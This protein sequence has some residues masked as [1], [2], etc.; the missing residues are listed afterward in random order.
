[1]PIYDGSDC[2]DSLNPVFE[3]AK[4]RIGERRVAILN[5]KGEALTKENDVSSFWQR[6]LEGLESS[7]VY[8]VP[9]A[10]LYSAIDSYAL[11]ISSGTGGSLPVFENN[12]FQLEGTLWYS[13]KE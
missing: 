13:R 4:L 9:F 1:M 6:T 8:D 5:N 12:K 2:V 11:G 7:N 10:L 3:T